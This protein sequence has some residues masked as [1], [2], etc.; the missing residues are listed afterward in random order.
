MD[1][2]GRDWSEAAWGQARASRVAAASESGERPMVPSPQPSEGT[3]ACDTFIL[4][5]F[6]PGLLTE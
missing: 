1:R 3:W 5:I 4:E 6:L 2:G